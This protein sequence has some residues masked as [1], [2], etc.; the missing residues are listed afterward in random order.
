MYMSLVLVFVFRIASV[1]KIVGRDRVRRPREETGRTPRLGAVCFQRRVEGSR[2]GEHTGAVGGVRKD[3][4]A[5][6]LSSFS[7]DP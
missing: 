1:C 3:W 6:K 4:G 5:G 2:G 7:K